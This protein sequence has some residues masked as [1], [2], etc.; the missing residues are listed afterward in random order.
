MIENVSDHRPVIKEHPFAFRKAFNVKGRHFAVFHLIDQMHRDG[1]HMPVAIAVTDQ[2]IMS[3]AGM[4]GNV[5]K[6]RFFGLLVLRQ[7]A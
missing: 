2:E 5:Q 3:K 4:L 6:H 1:L 7:C